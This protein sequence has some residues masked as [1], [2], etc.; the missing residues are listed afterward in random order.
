MCSQGAGG[1]PIVDTAG[2]SRLGRTG[3]GHTIDVRAWSNQYYVVLAFS[4][5]TRLQTYRDTCSQLRVNG[6]STIPLSVADDPSE[7]AN[8]ESNSG[9]PVAVATLLGI[10]ARLDRGTRPWSHVLKFGDMRVHLKFKHRS[11]WWKTRSS[12]GQ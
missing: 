7:C 11:G 2:R 10:V 1:K 12:L 8:Q 3:L 4:L 5:P 6:A 9:N